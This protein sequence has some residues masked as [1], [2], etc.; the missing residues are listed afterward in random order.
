MNEPLGYAA[1]SEDMNIRQSTPIS[2]K[3]D[4]PKTNLFLTS[5]KRL[6]N[7]D[8]SNLPT[9]HRT[10]I[11]LPVKIFSGVPSKGIHLKKNNSELEIYP[12]ANQNAHFL[13]G[14]GSW[15]KILKNHGWQAQ[16]AYYY[17]GTLEA[18]LPESTK[19]TASMMCLM[20][21]KSGKLISHRALVRLR[22]QKKK[23]SFSFRPGSAVNRFNL[24]LY[25]PKSDLPEK[26]I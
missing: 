1:A 8:H 10:P 9:E 5:W 17:R 2:K 12:K 13:F 7:A 11:E 21:D 16:I 15:Y 18:E 26:I 24:A 25:M 6:F 20:Y 4:R 23:L 14:G 19:G 22:Y 3:P